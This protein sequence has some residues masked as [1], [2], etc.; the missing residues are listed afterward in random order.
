MKSL[1]DSN[2]FH[3]PPTIPLGDIISGLWSHSLVPICGKEKERNSKV[4]S[5][6]LKV[7]MTQKLHIP[8]AYMLLQL[9]SY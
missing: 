9:T 6:L 5:L 2:S 8:S 4:S 1:K 7:E 3:F